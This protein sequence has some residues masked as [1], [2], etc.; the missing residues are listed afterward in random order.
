MSNIIED[1]NKPF[2]QDA[3]CYPPIETKKTYAFW[4][5]DQYPYFLGGEVYVAKSKY[6][7]PYVPSYQSSFT[8]IL[9][10]DEERGV[11][12]MEKLEHL[13]DTYREALFDMHR[14]FNELLKE[15]APEIA[16][17]I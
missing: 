17:K 15:V 3:G 5:Y 2:D 13:Q 12:L 11:V 7:K 8:P 10:T 4:K 6:G 16:D 9:V 14:E 1:R